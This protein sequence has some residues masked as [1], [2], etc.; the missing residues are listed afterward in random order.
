MDHHL[1]THPS[2]S[3]V[4]ILI[5]FSFVCKHP[6]PQQQQLFLIMESLL[7]TAT[8]K[9]MQLGE[10]LG[11]RNL[12]PEP[13]TIFITGG[14][15][16]I[17]Y[18]V[19]S[20]L[21][22]AEYHD[23]LRLGSHHPDH[24][25]QLVNKGA[26]VVDF[27]WDD[28]TTYAPALR[29]VKSVLCTV[30]YFQDWQQHFPN[31]LKACEKAGVRHFVKLSFYGA[32]VSGSPFQQVPMVRAHGDCDELLITTLTP[33]VDNVLLGDTDVVVD[34]VRPHMGYTILY[35][36]HYMSNPFFFFRKSL[37]NDN[38]A[39]PATFYGA[40]QN[41]GVNYV[42]PNDV[43]EVALRVL[44]EPKPHYNHEYVLTGPGTITDQEVAGLL[45]KHLDKAVM[46]V[47][48][49]SHE[50]D[51]E[52]RFTFFPDWMVQDLVALEKVKASGYEED[53]KFVSN[54]IEKIL[55]RKAETYQDYIQK[56]DRMTSIEKGHPHKEVEGGNKVPE[57][58]F[59]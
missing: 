31:F 7:K 45:S 2:A 57:Q 14:T 44:L 17:G 11:I 50:F 8:T 51:Y 49:P 6:K 26:Q 18:R 53:P 24:L 34:Y 56:K 33:K 5:D 16:V 19:A 37:D 1:H 42:S 13:G 55:G 15:G 22:Q 48:Q 41:R 3:R 32:R 40:S 10:S 36:S 46:Y 38:N 4:R 28:E 12:D 43:T 30:G 20:L 58:V 35:P 25:Q 9:L 59:H 21:L 39:T 47:D 27:S 54:D 23:Q 52:L 29:G